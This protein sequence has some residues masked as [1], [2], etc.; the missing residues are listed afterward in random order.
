[1]RNLIALVTALTTTG[2]ALAACD[3]GRAPCKHFD[4]GQKV[5]VKA[6]PNEAYAVVGFGLACGVYV[7]RPGGEGSKLFPADV[8]EASGAG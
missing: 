6:F 7:W 2:I 5:H 4:M 1:M 8:L 3:D